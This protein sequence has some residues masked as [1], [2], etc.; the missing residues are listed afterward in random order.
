MSR[1]W[2]DQVLHRVGDD[3]LICGA[4]ASGANAQVTVIAPD[5][6]TRIL[7]EFQPPS[8]R[9]C[10][11]MR[12]DAPGLYVLSLIVKDAGGTEIDRQSGAISAGP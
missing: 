5:H 6:S 10:Y 9:V 2:S 11:S 8:E 7:G 1:V 3:A 4:A 12:L